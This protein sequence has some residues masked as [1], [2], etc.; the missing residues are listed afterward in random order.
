[1]G[2]H[3][4]AHKIVC[5]VLPFLPKTHFLTSTTQQADLRMLIFLF[6]FWSS[7]HWEKSRVHAELNEMLVVPKATS[8]RCQSREKVLYICTVSA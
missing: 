2:F 6:L 1:M 5:H 4:Y 8:L 3:T 7:A